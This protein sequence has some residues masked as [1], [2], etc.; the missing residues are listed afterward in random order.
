MATQGKIEIRQFLNRLHCKAENHYL[1]IFSHALLGFILGQALRLD[2]NFQPILILSSVGLDIDALSIRSREAA[3]RT[4]RGPI[5]SIFAALLASLTMAAVYTLLMRQPATSLLSVISICLVGFFSHLLLD[6]STTG[7]IPALWP[8][9]RKNLALN[10]T[11]FIDPTF[12]GTLLIAALI[13]I[14]LKTDTTATQLITATAITFLALTSGL[15]YCEKNAATKILKVL[16]NGVA[17]EIVSL[18]TLRPDRWWMIRKI[19]FENGYR[20]EVYRIDSID[21]KIL[22]KESVES[23]Y[24]GYNGPAEPPIDS[25]LKAAACSR[26]D[27]RISASIDRF[28]LPAVK[29]TP[30]SNGEMWQVL[31]YDAFARASRGKHRGISADIKIDGTITVGTC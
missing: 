6:V 23:P 26:R 24:A 8:F 16:G 13:I 28:L 11:H 15:R 3:L 10:L 14:I 1:D 20:Y 9:S 22:G 19:P 30:S 27:K 7:G 25:P 17:A 2:I 18:P 29:I 4:H 21:N 12:L 5:H 31:W